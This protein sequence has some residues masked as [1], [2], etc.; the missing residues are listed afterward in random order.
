MLNVPTTTDWLIELLLFAFCLVLFCFI[1]A[2]I[3][4]VYLLHRVCNLL[5]GMKQNRKTQ[6][7]YI[8]YGTR[9]ENSLSIYKYLHFILFCFV[10]F[11]FD[12]I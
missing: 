8:K 4:R 9:Q 10:L 1:C 11:A 12:M 2:T 7:K 6:Y 3:E 5:T